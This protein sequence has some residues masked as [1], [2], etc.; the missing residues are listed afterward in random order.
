VAAV[1]ASRIVAALPVYGYLWRPNQPGQ[2]ISFDDAR[3]AAAQAN[4]ELRRDPASESLHAVQ[5]NAWELWFSDAV[6]LRA[7]EDEVTTLG[8]T[9]VALWRLG[10][11][12]P[13]IWRP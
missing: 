3:H 10:L 7:L 4:V 2:P 11:E 12:D 6:L 1:G 8:V 5:P 13:G 9:R